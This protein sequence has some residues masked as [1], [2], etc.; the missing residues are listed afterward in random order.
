MVILFRIDDRLIHAQVVVG[1][2]RALKPDRIVIADDPVSAA[3][4]ERELY[5]SA[6][7]PDFK[8]SIL[9]EREAVDMVSGGIFESEKIFLLV[10]GPG[11]ALG[12]LEMGLEV[13]EINVGGLHYREGRDKITD[14]VYV[15]EEERYLLREIVKKGIRLDARALPDDTKHTINSKVV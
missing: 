7:L 6:A 3:E 4:W 11:Q 5:A 13:E 8:V 2:G 14:N 1:W 15:N 10:R 9:S 12:L